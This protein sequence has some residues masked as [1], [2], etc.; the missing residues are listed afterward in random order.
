MTG[1]CAT[2]W[3]G[4]VLEEPGVWDLHWILQPRRGVKPELGG[5]CG[6]S[7]EGSTRWQG[8]GGGE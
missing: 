6:H 4:N 7:A 8:K 3:A 1:P 2:L 5:R